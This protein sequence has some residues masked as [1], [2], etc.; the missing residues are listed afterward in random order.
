LPEVG[1]SFVDYHDPLD[2]PG[3]LALVE[4]VLL[5]PARLAQ[6]EQRIRAEYRMTTWR[7]CAE[8]TRTLLERHWQ[9]QA[10]RAA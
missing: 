6:R 8:Q 7:D 5:E 3:C 2:A 1:G 9:I 4:R 10:R